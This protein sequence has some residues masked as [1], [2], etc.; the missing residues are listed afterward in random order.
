[1]VGSKGGII[2]NNIYKKVLNMNT[3][4]KG[5]IYQF[6]VTSGVI[7]AFITGVFSLMVSWNTNE[8]LKDI[9]SQKY[10]YSLHEIRYEKLYEYLEYFSS[11]RLFESKYI[12][13]FNV[14]EGYSV[15]DAMNIMYDATDDFSEHLDLLVPYLSY[16]S[17]AIIEESGIFD[18]DFVSSYEA[19]ASS[20]K[21]ITDINESMKKQMELGNSQFEEFSNAIVR[22]ISYEIGM[23][24]IPR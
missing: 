3:K 15:E 6:L 11:F 9:E 19:K 21:D 14:D 12:Y 24:Y 16:D 18:D 20:F 4:E 10:Q 17:Y 5:K 8:K 23:D 13:N 22:A 7:G 2:K 1:M